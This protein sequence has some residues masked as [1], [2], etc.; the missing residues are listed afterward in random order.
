[1]V[2]VPIRRS[3]RCQAVGG[4]HLYVCCRSSR[5]Q[6]HVLMSA[7]ALTT[8]HIPLL[9]PPFVDWMVVCWNGAAVLR[10]LHS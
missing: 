8:A 3:A 1:M 2:E 9:G 7:C 5:P 4:G 6:S 10:V